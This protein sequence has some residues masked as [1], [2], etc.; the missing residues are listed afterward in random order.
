MKADGFSD[1]C[2]TSF[3]P[4][5]GKTRT[6]NELRKLGIFISP[7]GVRSVWLRH[8]LAN[9]KNRI[10][11]LEAEVANEG[12]ILTEA[13]VQALEKIALDDEACGE[14]ETTQPGYLGSQD[15]F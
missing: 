6:S 7:S 11:A 12:L 8:N 10:K 9:L 3:I 13:Q 14:I 4:A 5:N 1:W 2:C 15:M